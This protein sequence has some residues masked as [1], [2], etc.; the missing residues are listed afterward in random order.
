MHITTLL[1]LPAL[2]A[3]FSLARTNTSLTIIPGSHIA[4]R[5]PQ[6]DSV[7]DLTGLFTSSCSPHYIENDTVILASSFEHWDFSAS[8][9]YSSPSSFI[10][11]AI[12]AWGRHAHL[13]LRPDDLWFT[14]LVQMNYYMLSN[15]EA[16]RPI[17]V[18]H[19]GKKE[20]IIE[21]VTWDAVISRFRGQIQ[22]KI[23]TKWMADWISPSFS[24]ST[25]DDELT[26]TVLTMGLMKAYFDYT[27][28]IICGIPSITL[29]G[30]KQDWERLQD[31]VERISSFGKGAEQYR[32]R[33][34]PI[35]KRIVASFDSPAAPTTRAFWDE[36]VQAKQYHSDLCGD[37]PTQ[38]FVSGWILGFFYWDD[39]EEVNRELSQGHAWRTTQATLEYDGIRYGELPLEEIPQGYATTKVKLI[40]EHGGPDPSKPR[41]GF[42]AAGNIGKHVIHGVPEQ[43][44]VAVH[45]LQ[46]DTN[47]ADSDDSHSTIQPL[48]GWFLAGGDLAE[49]EKQQRQKGT[50]LSG[51]TV[52]AIDACVPKSPHEEL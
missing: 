47:L 32:D 7:K 3:S 30:T 18:A 25:I 16:V 35:M 40:N 44:K 12:E 43:Y 23:K 5:H 52:S 41:P 26:A 27:M 10:R 11:S 34:R 39:N 50:E 37:P 15:A 8:A 36:M 22:S 17:F 4:K 28:G 19:E 9:T 33:L 6:L 24:T 21:D 20:I 42:V 29:L 13:V 14:I 45:A 31:K 48:S 38:Y 2:M 1:V 51:D 46:L 49:P